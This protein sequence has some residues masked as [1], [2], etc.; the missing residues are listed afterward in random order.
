[1]DCKTFLGCRIALAANCPDSANKIDSLKFTGEWER[2]PS[3]LSSNIFYLGVQ[4]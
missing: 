1:M 3:L 4:R 2:V